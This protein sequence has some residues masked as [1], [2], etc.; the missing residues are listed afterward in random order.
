MKGHPTMK[1]TEPRQ[2]TTGGGRREWKRPTL[3]PAGTVNSVLQSGHGKVTVVTG[4]P[5]E[6]HKVAGNDK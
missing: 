6:P 1:T 4:D 5:G 3:T 2:T